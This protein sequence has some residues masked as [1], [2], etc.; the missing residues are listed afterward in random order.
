[1]KP[2]GIAA[3]STMKNGVVTMRN[4]SRRRRASTGVTIRVRQ[5]RRVPACLWKPN[6]PSIAQLQAQRGMMIVLG[7]RWNLDPKGEAR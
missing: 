1:M 2:L 7:N 5:V 3:E 6:D 4:S